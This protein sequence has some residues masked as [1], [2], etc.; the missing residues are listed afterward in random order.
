MGTTRGTAPVRYSS[1]RSARARRSPESMERLRNPARCCRTLAWRRGVARRVIPSMNVERYSRASR[2]GSQRPALATSRPARPVVDFAVR[3]QQELVPRV[4]RD[5]PSA[6]CTRGPS[7]GASG[8]RRRRAR[9]SSRATA[10]RSIGPL[11]RTGAADAPASRHART[12]PCPMR[13]DFPG[14]PYTLTLAMPQLGEPRLKMY[15]RNAPM[16]GT[17]PPATASS[18]SVT[19][20]E[21]SAT[22][23]A[24]GCAQGSPVSRIGG[25]GT[26]S[27]GQ[28]LGTPGDVLEVP[29]EHAGH[30]AI[31]LVAAVVAHR[32]AEQATAHPDGD[33]LGRPGMRGGRGRLAHRDGR[34]SGV[35]RNGAR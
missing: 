14:A 30:V 11:P 6:A 10:H 9:R 18:A 26:P 28:R 27:P 4:E 16:S 21:V 17:A 33:A 35:I 12:P 25:R 19:S 3:Q 1:M 23:T 7:P 2:T 8:R 32:L 13:G 24:R 22:R 31:V 15:P 34:W 20:T 5:Q 29:P